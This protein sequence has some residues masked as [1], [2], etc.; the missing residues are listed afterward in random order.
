M[1][2]GQAGGNGYKLELAWHALRV[3]Y[4]SLDENPFPLKTLL[5]ERWPL[6]TEAENH[7]LWN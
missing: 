4:E 3:P 1:A 6:P 7:L 2:E 5:W